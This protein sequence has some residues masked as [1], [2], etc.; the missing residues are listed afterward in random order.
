MYDFV[1]PMFQVTHANFKM[2]K[3]KV[4]FKKKERVPKGLYIEEPFF[5]NKN[6]GKTRS[7]LFIVGEFF[8]FYIY[9]VHVLLYFCT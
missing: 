1:N 3:E 9:D 4:M 8:L 2:A 7:L 5:Y 6:L